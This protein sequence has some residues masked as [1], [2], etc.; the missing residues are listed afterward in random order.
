M[1]YEPKNEKVLRVWK[2]LSPE[3]REARF[4]QAQKKLELI[5]ALDERVGNE[6]ERAASVRLNAG[7]DRTT[8][9]RWREKYNELGFDGLISIRIGPYSRMP[10]EIQSTICTLRRM[11]SNIN[12]EDIISHVK[13]HHTYKTSGTTVKR[14]LRENGLNRN[15]GGQKGKIPAAVDQRL[16]YG[17][18]KLLEAA[19]VETGYVGAL[20]KAV[21]AHV[22]ELPRPEAPV[23]P[24][25]SGRDQFGRITSEYN[26]RY[27]K[28]AEDPIGPGYASVS[29][30]R[31]DTDPARMAIARTKESTIESKLLGLM[32]SPLIGSGR[33]DGMRAAHADIFLK[34]ACGYSYM[35]ATLDKFSR[36][37][38]YAG[39][40]GTLWEVHARFWLSETSKWGDERRAAVIYTDGTP[41][42]IWTNL[43]S[44]STKVSNV[45]RIMPGLDVVAFHSGY[46]VPLWML[47]HSGRAP[48]VNVLPDAINKFDEICDPYPATGILVID[49]EGNSI[50]FVKGLEQGNPGRAWIMRL[51][52]DWVRGKKIF[53]RTNYRAYRNGDRV[54]MGLADFND[55]EAPDGGKFRMRV[56]EVERRTSG[57]VIY[58]GASTLLHELDWRPADIADLYFDRWPLQEANFRA[59]NQAAGFKNVHG[60]GKQLVDNIS[61]ITKLDGLTRKTGNAEEL[62]TRQQDKLE[63]CEK[64]V[65][66]ENKI[67][68]RKMRRRE[69]VRRHI[70]SKLESGKTATP[71]LQNLLKEQ[72]D[73]VD[74]IAQ[75]KEHL[76]KC[77]DCYDQA[78]TKCNNTQ[79]RLEGYKKEKRK[80]E[81]QREIFA[82]DVELDS[83]F[84]LLKVGL[85]LIITYI[86]KEYFGGAC[87]DALTFL[88]RLATLPARLRVT[89]DL[90]I[91]TFEY[92]RRDP[93]MMA[94][95]EKYCESINSRELRTR[96]NRKLRIQVDPA[97]KR[98]RPPP[99]RTRCKSNGRFIR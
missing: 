54:R 11:D 61:V 31:K 21:S 56:I 17:G 62:L 85:V 75:G 18:M 81:S 68:N 89:P 55:P 44:Q 40:A 70:E 66:E 92:N 3:A 52:D 4:S 87:M 36:E 16:E 1:E 79:T 60:Y 78:K 90:E 27:R 95:L 74:D 65:C 38:K 34:E 72:Y 12:V 57:K 50:P 76:S 73:L 80:L 67:L 51:R 41:K 35:P 84:S 6:S 8:I 30:K 82:H 45:G 14:V 53:K 91:V 64:K 48:L 37:L 86:L 49:A 42:G 22:K 28:K 88:E 26:E 13:K 32:A 99:D 15:R 63:I 25:K 47:T 94:L 33:W 10:E 83:L 58:I 93:D 43:F 77:Q 59:V 5:N 9:R 96:S 23:E 24:D 39:V 46:G 2:R 71:S 97:P 19:C 29:E 98:N 20:A 69:T 7:F